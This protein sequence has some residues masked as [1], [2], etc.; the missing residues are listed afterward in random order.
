MCSGD[1]VIGEGA[2]VAASGTRTMFSRLS[3]AT[4]PTGAQL[5]G[6][7]ILC[8]TGVVEGAGKM[9]S[10]CATDGSSRYHRE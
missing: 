3:G 1:R 5:F 10:L 7:V 4:E 8:A 2:T 9:G 6:R